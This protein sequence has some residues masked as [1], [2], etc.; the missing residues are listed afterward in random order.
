MD[1][2]F[3]FEGFGT[4]GFPGMWNFK[5]PNQAGC[6]LGKTGGGIKMK[7]SGPNIYEALEVRRAWYVVRIK[8][9]MRLGRKK[10]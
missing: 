3:W 7:K 8:E 5:C 1:Q 6:S 2:L 10:S 4:V 9:L